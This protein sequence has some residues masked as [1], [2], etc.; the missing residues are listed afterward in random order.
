MVQ[1]DV[2][3]P[4]PSSLTESAAL[5]DDHRKFLFE[6]VCAEAEHLNQCWRLYDQLVRRRTRSDVE[7]MRAIAPIFFATTGRLFA[8]SIFLTIQRLLDAAGSRDGKLSASLAALIPSNPAPGDVAVVRGLKR[9]LER[10]RQQST[11]TKEWRHRRI[12]HHDRTVALQTK[13]LSPVK[14]R[15]VTESE[16]GIRTFLDRYGRH[17]YGY[18]VSVEQGEADGDMLLLW[19]ER[20][21][22]RQD[23]DEPT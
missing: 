1:R 23:A 8:E 3:R 18:D 7:T 20:A 13:Q 19:L 6:E 22:R 16:A 9:Q 5:T 2:D 14:L 17:F 11:G 12:A 10:L 15:E 4:R 21:R